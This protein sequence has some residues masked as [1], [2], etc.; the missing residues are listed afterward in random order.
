MHVRALDAELR[1]NGTRACGG[2]GD[3]GAAGSRRD[4]F[5]PLAT[6]PV[7]RVPRRK[8]V[9]LDNI[10]RNNRV[11]PRAHVL[12][13]LNRVEV[14]YFVDIGGYWKPDPKKVEAAMRASPTFNA[15]LGN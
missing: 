9:L 11:S 5:F 15:I 10:R 4:G 12:V 7:M 6:L 13:L 14:D 8:D 1:A 2:G 3:C